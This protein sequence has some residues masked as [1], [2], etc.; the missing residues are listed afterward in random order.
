MAFLLNGR[1]L[2]LDTPFEH[3]GFL[4]PANWLRLASAEEKAAIGITE[5]APPPVYD[6]RFYWGV[7]TPKG[8]EPLKTQWVATIKETAGQLL[9]RTDWMVVRQMDAGVEIP[10]EVKELRVAIRQAANDKEQMLAAAESVEDLC[11]FVT[12]TDFFDWPSLPQEP[13][14]V[15]EEITN[16]IEATLAQDVVFEE[17]L[18][19]PFELTE[20]VTVD[21]TQVDVQE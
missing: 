15:V 16:T 10:Q 5:V 1:P 7:D 12:G 4:Y 2:A 18:F 3:K 11:A 17:P 6:Q 20:E 13:E 14:P 8:L 9:A 19:P 21:Q